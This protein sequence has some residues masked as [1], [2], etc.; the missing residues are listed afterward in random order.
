MGHLSLT[1]PLIGVFSNP[2]A[3]TWR[4]VPLYKIWQL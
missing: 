4:S 2:S 3:R 1:T